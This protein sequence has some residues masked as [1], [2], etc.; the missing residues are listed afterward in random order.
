MHANDTITKTKKQTN[1]TTN[2]QCQDELNTYCNIYKFKQ[3]SNTQ[4]KLSI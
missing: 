4:T 2:S 1:K 3:K